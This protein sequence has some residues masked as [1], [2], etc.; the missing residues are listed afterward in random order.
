MLRINPRRPLAAALLVAFLG[1]ALA[2][3]PAAGRAS[4]VPD[5][6]R[7]SYNVWQGGFH[8]FT[9]RTEMNHGA[10]RYDASFSATTDGLVGW[11]FPYRVE[12]RSKGTLV[13][14]EP[15]T[16]TG[17]MNG[18]R[19]QRF[20]SA[21]RKGDKEKQREITYL[22]DG[23]LEVR[24]QPPRD[25]EPLA[26]PLLRDTLDPV[27]ALFAIIG[28]FDEVR[29]CAGRLSVFDGRRRYDLKLKQLGAAQLE[30]SDYGIYSGPA[31]RCRVV[32][33]PIAG[34]KNKRKS[35]SRLPRKV[36]VWLAPL[37]PG[38]PAVPVRLEGKNPWGR[39]VVHLISAETG[40]TR[41]HASR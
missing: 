35:L 21:S 40:G 16:G 9:L 18:F 15:E 22:D 5:K 38:G 33:K 27:T 34:F 7:L 32:L 39:M 31:M 12:G 17:V 41:T 1:S 2:A 24:H 30:P 36:E 28:S 23:S 11:I 10:E 8:A 4:E 19:P 20:E 29:R 3:V 25:D 37:E 26:E 14:A 6:L 13:A